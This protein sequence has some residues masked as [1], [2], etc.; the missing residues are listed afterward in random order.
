MVD[1]ST[2]AAIVRTESA[3]NPHA[4]GINGRVR[5][6]RQPQTRVEAIATAKWLI[7]RGYNIDM[8]LGQINSAN[9]PRLRLSVEDVFDPCKNLHA[10]ATILQASYLKAKQSR[11]GEQDALHAAFSAYNTGSFSRGFRNGYVQ[12]VLHSAGYGDKPVKAPSQT[13][14]ALRNPTKDSQPSDPFAEGVMVYP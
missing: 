14:R 3:F 9:L 1:P 11:Q 4:I 10:A 12:K 5:L 13:S 6:A 8:G 7:G 2:L